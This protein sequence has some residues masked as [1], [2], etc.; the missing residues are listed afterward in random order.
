MED[1]KVKS[2]LK[3]II[4]NLVIAFIIIFALNRIILPWIVSSDPISVPKVVGM[5]KED[6]KELL[7]SKGLNPIE[8]GVRYDDK[9]PENH[10][11]YQRPHEGSKV[12][13]NR[14]I[15]IYISGGEQQIVMP[16]LIGRTI[17]EARIILERSGLFISKVEDVES[18]ETAGIII[19][20]QFAEGTKLYQGDYVYL[21]VS[22]GPQMGKVK[23]PNL[24]SKSLK[25][26]EL[27]LRNSNLYVGSITYIRSS[28]LLNNTVIDQYPSSDNLVELGDSID[29][30]VSKSR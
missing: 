25:E 12:K 11:L 27:V 3:R 28:S 4:I 2:R 21:K 16:R 15:Y 24:I 7:V 14:R 1:K 19:A 10:I 26:A 23:V 9:I 6:A 17:R 5:S 20:Q 30:V 18:D 29:V 13:A 22:I 8:V